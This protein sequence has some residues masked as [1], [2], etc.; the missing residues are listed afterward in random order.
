MEPLPNELIIEIFNYILKITDKRQFLRTCIHYNNL[1]TQSMLNYEKNYNILHFIYQIDY[2]VEKFTLELCHDSY[3]NLIPE[4]YITK[5]NKIL[6]KCLAY[7][8]N[9]ELL[10]LAK[11]KGCDM[12]MDDTINFVVLAE[13]ISVLEWCVGNLKNQH[14][15]NAYLI[16]CEKI[17]ILIC[18]RENQ[19]KFGNTNIYWMC[20]NAAEFGQLEILKILRGLGCHWSKYTYELA[21][22]SGNQELVK[23][24]IDS[25][26]P[27]N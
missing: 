2:C 6:V 11:L 20:N 24:M 12:N 22:K 16:N 18:L 26:C 8:N 25:G 27:T 10:K 9:I 4:H 15:A 1:T 17:H 21:L 19:C 14:F 23:W 7:Y 13:H 3:F 5:S